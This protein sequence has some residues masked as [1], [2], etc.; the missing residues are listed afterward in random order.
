MCND[1]GSREA[2]EGSTTC[3]GKID[4]VNLELNDWKEVGPRIPWVALFWRV[5][6]GYPAKARPNELQLRVVQLSKDGLYVASS[7]GTPCDYNI[8]TSHPFSPPFLRYPYS[9]FYFL[10]LL[11]SF[12]S[13]FYFISTNTNNSLLITL[14][15][16]FN[17][18]LWTFLSRFLDFIFIITI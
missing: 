13:L 9:H 10:S 7:Q 8:L 1:S 11:L 15:L 2:G 17:E 16:F 6:I 5:L 4:W 3:L 12:T 14:N 18:I